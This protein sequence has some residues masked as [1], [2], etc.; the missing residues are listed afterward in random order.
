[1]PVVVVKRKRRRR[2]VPRPRL[3]ECEQLIY[4]AGHR[5][6]MNFHDEQCRSLWMLVVV[7]VK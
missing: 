5:M 7:V 6:M 1:M 4:V 3:G 2:L